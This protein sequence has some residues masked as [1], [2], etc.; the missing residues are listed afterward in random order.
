MAISY[1]S[2]S[3]S[4]NSNLPG[5][6]ITVAAPP[7]IQDGDILVAAIYQWVAD[8]GPDVTHPAGF[9]EIAANQND[10]EFHCISWKRASSESGS[11][12]FTFACDAVAVAAI[13]VLRGCLA[14]GS[15]VDVFS[16]TAYTTTNTT[17]RAASVTTTVANAMLVAAG[18]AWGTSSKGI[19]PP[20]GMT[21]AIEVGSTAVNGYS[22]LSIAYAE[23]ASSGASGNKDFTA[24]TSSSYKH[25]FLV[26]FKP[27]SAGNPWYAYA[28]Q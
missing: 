3:S 28:Q 19:T 20:A 27:D 25:A 8:E 22:K 24:G 2:Q 10:I 17:I 9:T 5:N 13:I 23:Q 21:E 15:P 6:S 4:N 12:T 18:S 1:V 7:N 14:S 16:N 26:A 11:Y